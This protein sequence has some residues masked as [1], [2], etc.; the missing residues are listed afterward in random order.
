MSST[1]RINKSNGGY[2]VLVDGVSLAG[3]VTELALTM[4]P[5]VPPVVKLLLLAKD[6]E[7]DLDE[8]LVQATTG[9]ED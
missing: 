3:S 6:V 9:E 4:S 8:V 7:V 5:D 2:E 1:L